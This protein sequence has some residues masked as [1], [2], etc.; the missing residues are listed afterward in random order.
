MNTSGTKMSAKSRSKAK[1]KNSNKKETCLDCENKVNKE[2]KA[3]ECEVCRSWF[4]IECQSVSER[5]YEVFNVEDS[6]QIHWYCKYCNR[7]SGKIVQILSS[8]AEATE[9]L[10]K[11]IEETE[12]EG[13]E[14]KKI[15][16]HNEEKINK[17]ETQINN[18]IKESNN[19]ESK[20]KVKATYA[21]VIQ[22]EIGKVTTE[23]I[24]AEVG[25]VTTEM[26]EQKKREKNLIIYRIKENTERKVEEEEKED[27]IYLKDL[28]NILEIPEVKI[29]SSTRLGK[30]QNDSSNS[31]PRP[32]RITLQ[33]KEDKQ[34]IFKNINKLK[35]SENKFKQISI[36]DDHTI[37]ERKKI[38]EK[39]EEANQKNQEEDVQSKNFMYKVRGPPW[40]LKIKKITTN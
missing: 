10:E 22:A 23:V 26:D 7:G 25:K 33:R 24:Q 29:I 13:R 9:M 35:T 31:K 11:R 39:I 12:E 5:V 3:L 14:T 38:K 8:M 18:I 36:T 32:T 28:W 4:H 6:N 40:N 15:A 1:I 34:I 2:D 17:L 27:K 20:E 21:E 30:K 16:K 19:E 37:E